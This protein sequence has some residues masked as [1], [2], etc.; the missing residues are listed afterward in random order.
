MRGFSTSW[1]GLLLTPGAIYN[2]DP[3][4]PANIARNKKTID[5]N[6]L[7]AKGTRL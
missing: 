7:H 6:A 3:K 4:V 1:Y 2:V 5:L